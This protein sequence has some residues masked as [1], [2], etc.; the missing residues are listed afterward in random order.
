MLTM[1]SGAN[2]ARPVPY[3][4]ARSIG[5]LGLRTLG[6]PPIYAGERNVFWR[7][8]ISSVPPSPPLSR[9]LTLPRVVAH[10]DDGNGRLSTMSISVRTT[11]AFALLSTFLSVC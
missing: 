5:E 6:V 9:V 3:A 7:M 8:F 11:C 10:L 4:D 1:T 2:E